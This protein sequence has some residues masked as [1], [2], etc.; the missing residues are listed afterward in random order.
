MLCT[1]EW[2]FKG[3]VYRWLGIGATIVIAAISFIT[4]ASLYGTVMTLIFYFLKDK[5]MW[6]AI[7]YVFVSLGL[8]IGMASAYIFE[9]M[10]I[11][12]Y[13]WAMVFAIPF[14]LLYNGKRGLNNPITKYMFY[15]FYPLHLWIIY[16][17]SYFIT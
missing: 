14:I 3:G 5:K 2:S 11:F 15:I 7:I 13:Q 10:F 12:D 1:I 17:I 9:A 16:I 4:E 6:M 8:T